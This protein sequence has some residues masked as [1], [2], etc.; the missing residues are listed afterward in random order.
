MTQYA[1]PTADVTVES[2]T[3]YMGNTIGWSDGSGGTS[4]IYQLVDEA[5]LNT[6]DYA[7]YSS[8]GGE[9]P[10]SLELQLGT[11]SEPSDLTTVVVSI[12]SKRSTS[13]FAC[14]IYLKYG[15]TNI[16][17]WSMPADGSATTNTTALSSTE[18]NAIKSAVST[19]GHSDWSDLHLKF[20]GDDDN[21][22]KSAYVYQCFVQ[23][24]AAGG[25]GG[26]TPIAAISMNHYRQQRI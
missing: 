5:T 19:A 22:Y 17:S 20:T 9:N 26:S 4:N 23:A 24:G 12:T 16:K 10:R 21:P 3:G 14:T 13:D 2:S 1:R 7:L 25:G 18:A 11:I 15:S 6:G 8:A